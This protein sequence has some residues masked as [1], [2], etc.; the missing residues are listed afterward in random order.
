MD[1]GLNEADFRFMM[2]LEPDGCFIVLENEKRVGMAT[3]VT[4]G[5]VGWVGNVIVVESHRNR[6]VG[7]LL[8]R[9]AVD[10]LRDRSVRTVGLYAY[11]Q[12]IPFYERLGFVSDAGFV[13]MRGSGVSSSGEFLSREGKKR[14][15]PNILALD[16]FCFGASRER[17]L[18]S[19]FSDRRNPSRVLYDE[20]LLGFALAKRRSEMAE[21]GPVVC[22][23]SS[24]QV[25]TDLLQ[26]VLQKL[27]G[28]EVYMYVAEDAKSVLSLLGDYGF[29]ESFRLTRMFLGEPVRD[30]GCLL[31]A[32][33]LER[34]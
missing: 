17:L 19:I 7:S 8:V 9:H 2:D 13:V 16:G 21:V 26:A 12:A 4:F 31:A 11:L 27:Q 20:E 25:S 18:R 33:S 34:G 5:R 6:G 29:S 14:D 28:L 1:W 32:E 24:P 22:R 30:K 23:S 3:A 10:F 15:L